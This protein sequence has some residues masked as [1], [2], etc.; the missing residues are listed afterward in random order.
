M[1]EHQCAVD[2]LVARYREQCIMFPRTTEIPLAL[3]IRRNRP[4][5]V[6]NWREL[7]REYHLYAWEH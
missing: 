1:T 7:A 5:V 3:Y 2:Y 6:R 4:Q